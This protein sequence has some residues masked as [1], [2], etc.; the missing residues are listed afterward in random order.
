MR[1]QGYPR[2]ADE[3]DKFYGYL[4]VD[5]LVDHPRKIEP[6]TLKAIVLD[7]IKYASRKSVV[8]FYQSIQT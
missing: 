6:E 4:D 5:V 3:D 1:S 2:I 8:K 7:G